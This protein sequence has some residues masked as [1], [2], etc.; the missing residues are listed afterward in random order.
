MNTGQFARYADDF[1]VMVRSATVARRVM[2][3][4]TRF[5]E[6]SLKLVVNQRKSQAARLKQWAFLGIQI[7][8][9]GKVM[10]TA[11][12][13]ARF[14]QRIREI[15]SRSRGHKVGQVIDKRRGYVIG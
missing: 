11:K 9:R 1:L 3:S 15:T 10:W 8:W 2:K 4:L 5:I 6:G 14:K 7:E 13:L 12:A